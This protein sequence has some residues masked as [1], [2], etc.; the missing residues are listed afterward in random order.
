M[1]GLEI[2]QAFLNF[3]LHNGMI[4]SPT[5]LDHDVE[6]DGIHKDEIEDE[7]E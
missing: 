6:I 3:L 1:N 5:V 4:V 7:E 2:Q